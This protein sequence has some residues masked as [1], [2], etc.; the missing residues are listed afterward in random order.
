EGMRSIERRRV[1][2]LLGWR[3]PDSDISWENV[4][5]P[6]ILPWL[7]DHKVGG[8]MVYP[9]A[10]YLEMALAAAREWLG[11]ALI[12]VDELDILAP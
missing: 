9:G 5:D 6:V 4:L 3:L 12:Q 10:A 7:A 2:D 8:A 1:H 11:E